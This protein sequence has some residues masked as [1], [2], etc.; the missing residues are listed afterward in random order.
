MCPKLCLIVTFKFSHLIV[1]QPFSFAGKAP[2]K[3]SLLYQRCRK[4]EKKKSHR[5]AEMSVRM[6]G[7]LVPLL[8]SLYDRRT[9]T[10]ASESCLYVCA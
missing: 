3:L 10:T 1:F 5:D 6:F 7:S 4:N 9:V 8:N 2:T